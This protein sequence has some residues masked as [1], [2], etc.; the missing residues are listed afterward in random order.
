MQTRRRSQKGDLPDCLSKANGSRQD[1]GAGVA[2]H[3]YRPAPVRV[4]G[5]RTAN[6]PEHTRESVGDSL[7]DAQCGRGAA[8]RGDDEPGQQRGD[9]LMSQ[10]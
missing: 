8:Q 5:E 7:D 2:R 10:V 3:G 6:Q 9:D 1:G 4:V